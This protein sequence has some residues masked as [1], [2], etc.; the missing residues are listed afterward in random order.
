MQEF[1]VTVILNFIKLMT[2]IISASQFPG[3]LYI[4]SDNK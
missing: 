1:N 4:S 3:I 2:K